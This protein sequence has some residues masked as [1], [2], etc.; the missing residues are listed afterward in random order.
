MHK[1]I[2]FGCH[3]PI[4]LVDGIDGIDPSD[5]HIWDP[6]AVH[7]IT[8]IHTWKTPSVYM[9][10]LAHMKLNSLI[11]YLAQHQLVV[12]N[13]GFDKPHSKP[14]ALAA[15]L[16][17]LVLGAAYS[18]FF[19]TSAQ[20]ST[21]GRNA[22]AAPDGALGGCSQIGCADGGNHRG[23]APRDGSHNAAIEGQLWSSFMAWNS[24]FEAIISFG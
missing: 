22:V 19:V 5:P 23:I 7:I 8:H 14:A 15:F 24:P 2:F 3:R 13:Q 21:Q 10:M 11:A 9:L 12:N 20:P 17:Q 16:S 4:L 1:I 6:E 18:H